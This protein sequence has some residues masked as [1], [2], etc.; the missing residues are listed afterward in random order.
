MN[1]MKKLLKNELT[2]TLNYASFKVLMTLHFVLFLLVI[3]IASKIDIAV[4]GFSMRN[5]FRF[6]DVWATF[7]WIASWFNILLAIM[8]IVLV[9]N[10]FSFR[11]FRQQVINGLSV[12]DLVIGKGIVIF[13]IALYSLLLVF[14]LGSVFGI[15]F[16]HN[17]E[18]ADLFSKSYLLAVYFIQAVGYMIIGMLFAVIFRNNSLSIIMFLLYFIFIE[19]IIRRFFS[20]EVRQFFPVKIISHLTPPPEVL[21]I[22]SEKTIENSAG[23]TSFDFESIG[24]IPHQL[25]LFITLLLAIGF[26]ALFV[27]II[28]WVMRKRDL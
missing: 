7:A 14:L 15:M 1:K 28:F 4:P 9:G 8:V 11:T 18:F 3:I 21:A 17:F 26:I 13:L 27:F 12:D 23:T 25:S 16:S 6:P 22:A 24:L 2:K 5:L 10:E 20:P 19:P